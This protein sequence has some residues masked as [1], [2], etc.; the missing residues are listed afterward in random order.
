M[1]IL[2]L[3]IIIISFAIAIAII[4]TNNSLIKALRIENEEMIHDNTQ[5]IKIINLYEQELENC[6]S[7]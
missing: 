6:K 7:K 4:L 5:L 3:I 2:T 1:K